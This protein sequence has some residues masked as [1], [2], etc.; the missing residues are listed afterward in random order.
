[1]YYSTPGQRPLPGFSKSLDQRDTFRV[2]IFSY[3]YESH[4]RS[5][6]ESHSETLSKHASLTSIDKVHALY[7]F[8]MPL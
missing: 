6:P 5:L 8:N 3:K 7:F 2:L 1:M 4:T